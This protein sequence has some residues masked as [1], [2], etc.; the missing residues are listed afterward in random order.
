MAICSVY[1][2]R[3]SCSDSISKS[4]GNGSSETNYRYVLGFIAEHISFT[5]YQFTKQNC[6]KGV[7]GKIMANSV[8]S[9]KPFRFY[10]ILSKWF[11]CLWGVFNID[12][13]YT[14]ERTYRPQR[15]LRKCISRKLIT[16]GW[17]V[18]MSGNTYKPE[19]HIISIIHFRW[20]QPQNLPS[21]LRDSN[22]AVYK[23][24]GLKMVAIA[25]HRRNYKQYWF[26]K[27]D[28]VTF[29]LFQLIACV[30]GC[31]YNRTYANTSVGQKPDTTGMEQVKQGDV[32][33]IDALGITRERIL[34]STS[35]EGFPAWLFRILTLHSGSRY[36]NIS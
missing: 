17:G 19:L 23:G 27:G 6:F 3:N 24:P 25:V 30:C 7:L 9:T 14:V 28:P 13:Y 31:V 12:F 5:L 36:V 35:R 1:S 29:Y 16:S 21:K 11:T 34:L 4:G 33:P 2:R 26:K 20:G 15:I 32:R 8:Y 18:L 10:F 22:R